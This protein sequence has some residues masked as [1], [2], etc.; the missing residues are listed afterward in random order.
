[1]DPARSVPVGV[2]LAHR[3]FVRALA[4]RLARDDAGADDVEQ[5]AW[6]AAIERPPRHDRG[7]RAWL[8]RLV[9]HRAADARRA[10]GRRAA[11]E[12]VAAAAPSAAAPLETVERLDAMSRVVAAVARLPEPY[13]TTVV[14]RFYDDLAVAEI[15]ARTDVP[16]ATVRTRLTRAY[17]RLREELGI[18]EE[19]RDEWLA[20][21]APWPSGRRW[22]P[23]S[24]AASAA[25]AIV[26]S[27]KT[28]GVAAAVVAIAA[29]AIWWTRP[30]TPAPVAPSAQRSVAAAEPRNRSPAPA[31]S[32]ATPPVAPAEP[33]PAEPT[34]S[35]VVTVR[36]FREEPIPGAVVDVQRYA[37]GTPAAE[38][39]QTTR[40][41]GLARFPQLPA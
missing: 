31:P 24:A 21:V 6:L 33:A 38:T 7:L 39:R 27:V 19:T 30:S 14:L 25:G 5:T 3:E 26:M 41:D 36:T 9:R 29:G 18:S 12:S 11:H 40:E 35:L 37:P 15:A 13:R 28:W 22:T 10:A 34:G 8:A 2:L 20:L 1:M 23:A 4:R 32:S 17:A 16:P